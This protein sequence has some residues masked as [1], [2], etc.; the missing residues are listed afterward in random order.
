MR[1]T[2]CLKR[3][4]LLEDDRYCGEKEAIETGL[5]ILSGDYQKIERERSDPL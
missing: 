5:A 4:R 2:K 1:K 3:N